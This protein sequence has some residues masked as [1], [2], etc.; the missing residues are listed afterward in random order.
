MKKLSIIICAAIVIGYTGVHSQIF[1]QGGDA[2]AEYARQQQQVREQMEKSAAIIKMQ[3]EFLV[4][5]EKL[6]TK[7][8]EQAK[9]YDR[10]LDA[11][12]KQYKVKK[13]E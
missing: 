8:E 2:W 7:M 6:L 13:E 12:E 4:R 1:A 10:I 11:M 3:E 5:H 9:R